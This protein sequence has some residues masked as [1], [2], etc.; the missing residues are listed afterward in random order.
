LSRKIKEECGLGFSDYLNQMRI[1]K[2]K[3]MIRSGD[4]N[5]KEIV[6]LVGFNNYN[7]FFKVFKDL[8]GMTPSEYERKSK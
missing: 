8:E 5:I 3:E 2:A 7:Y 6:N 4:K 1:K